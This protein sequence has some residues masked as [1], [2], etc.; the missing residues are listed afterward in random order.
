VLAVHR[1]AARAWA[2]ARGLFADRDLPE[3]RLGVRH[4]PFPAE[5]SAGLEVALGRSPRTI[6]VAELHA[7]LCLPERPSRERL[8]PHP[9]HLVERF[10]RQRHLPG[11]VEDAGLERE[12]AR[13]L[14]GQLGDRGEVRRRRRQGQRV[15][16]LT[17]EALGVGERPKPDD[18]RG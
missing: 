18:A 1:R 15:S 7:V 10:A 3:Q 5:A 6:E 8:V 13:H 11:V 16:Q 17:A 12:A 9:V 14:T 4:V 2:S